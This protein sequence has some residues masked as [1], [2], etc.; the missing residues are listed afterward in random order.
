V[1]V[2]LL[3]VRL[4]VLEMRRLPGWRLMCSAAVKNDGRIRAGPRARSRRR[5]R[6]RRRRRRRL[7]W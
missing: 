2:L 6:R 1:L 4:V 3:V 7:G 5:K